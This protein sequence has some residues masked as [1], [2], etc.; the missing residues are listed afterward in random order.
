M[1]FRVYLK[2]WIICNKI[3]S[4]PLT[5]DNRKEGVAIRFAGSI[6]LNYPS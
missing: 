4:D 3:V 1:L 6:Q 5:K 2:D